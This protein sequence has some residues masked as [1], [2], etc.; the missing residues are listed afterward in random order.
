MTTCL[1]SICCLK[2]VY[3]NGPLFGCFLAFLG[4]TGVQVVA[5]VYSDS[6]QSTSLQNQ[7]IGTILLVL[8]IIFNSMGLIA[9][10]WIF[11]KY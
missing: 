2:R 7:V 4:I 8:S 5:I 3:G 1:L 11:N 10:K 9:E 6:S